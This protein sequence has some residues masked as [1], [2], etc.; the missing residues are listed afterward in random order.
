MNKNTQLIPMLG[1]SPFETNEPPNKYTSRRYNSKLSEPKF[2]VIKRKDHDSFEKIS[3][4]IFKKLVYIACGWEIEPLQKL[5]D[6]S[7]LMKT[8]ND[9]HAKN[10]LKLTKIEEKE[11]TAV[12]RKPFN[13]LKGKIYCNGR[14]IAETTI[15]Q[16]LKPQKFTEVRKKMKRQETT[17]TLQTTFW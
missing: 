3:K 1:Q 6:E 11:V 4:F 12:E 17:P 8:K 7:S 13:F 5:K 9:Q 14:Y 16:E 10:L 2:I 15:L